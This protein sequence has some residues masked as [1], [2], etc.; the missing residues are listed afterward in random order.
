[1]AFPVT[2]TCTFDVGGGQQLL[3]ADV[4][5]GDTEVPD[6]SGA[7]GDPSTLTVDVDVS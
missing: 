6:E 2:I 4:A 1:M 3:A 5:V 7:V